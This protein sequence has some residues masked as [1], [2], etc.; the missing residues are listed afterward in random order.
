M[1][2]CTLGYVGLEKQPFTAERLNF[3][4]NRVALVFAA[5]GNHNLGSFTG[6]LERRRLLRCRNSLLSLSLLSCQKSSSELA[7]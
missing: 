7:P 2:V 6:E 4:Y 1:P 3:A 5:R